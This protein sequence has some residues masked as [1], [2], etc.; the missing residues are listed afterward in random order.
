MDTPIA[1]QPLTA[2]FETATRPYEFSRAENQIIARTGSRTTIWGYITVVAGALMLLG[3][4]AG[5]IGGY[6]AMGAPGAL[7][8]LVYAAPALLFIFVGR[9][10]V[11][12]GAALGSIVT[13][14]GRD[15]R[16][17]LT[18]LEKLGSAFWVQ[19][20]VVVVTFVMALL[21]VTAGVLFG[22]LWPL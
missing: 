4:I 22:V 10:F 5:L 1:N 20:V 19:I 21:G 14:A 6:A 7:L 16:H 9:Q 15:I 13:T 8:G 11:Q 3:S 18:A 2:G 17:L 12:A